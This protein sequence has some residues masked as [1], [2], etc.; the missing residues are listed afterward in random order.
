MNNQN[1]LQKN[2]ASKLI[3]FLEDLYCNLLLETINNAKKDLPDQTE[4]E[5]K[6]VDNNQIKSESSKETTSEKNQKIN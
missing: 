3:N 4:M 2:Q 6:K 5:S 1:L